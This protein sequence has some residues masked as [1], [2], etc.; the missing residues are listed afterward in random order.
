MAE[1]A[2]PRTRAPRG[3][4]SV[5]QAFFNALH[6][7]PD[8]RRAEVARAAQLAI[9]DGLK[10]ARERAK[11]MAQKANATKVAVRAPTKTRRRSAAKPT[12]RTRAQRGGASA[13]I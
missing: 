11:T 10:G 1:T 13:S 2:F 7:I 8:M 3:T 12:V 6:E 5:T 9:R 4:K